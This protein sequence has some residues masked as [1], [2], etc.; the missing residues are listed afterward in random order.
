MSGMGLLVP[1]NKRAME[2]EVMPWLMGKIV[3]FLD[4]DEAITNGTHSVV[5]D[6]IV[7]CQDEHAA[8]IQKKYDAIK[9]MEE[10]KLE[11]KK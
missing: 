9:K 1:P 3:N 2:E 11:E 5:V 10:D 6:G 4:E 8:I 7:D